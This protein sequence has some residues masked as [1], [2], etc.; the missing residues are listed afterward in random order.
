[1]HPALD[2]AF[3]TATHASE[4]FFDALDKLLGAHETPIDR[5]LVGYQALGLVV[6]VALSTLWAFIRCVKP[7]RSKVKQ[8]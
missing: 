7:S 6:F 1:M 3:A 5:F 8:P 4:L 2:V